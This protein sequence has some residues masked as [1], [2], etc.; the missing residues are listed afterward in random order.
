MD[1][2]PSRGGGPMQVLLIIALLGG[3]G[4]WFFDRYQVD[5]VD[6]LSVRAKSPLDSRSSSMTLTRVAAR[7]GLTDDAEPFD[8]STWFTP[9]SSQ[10]IVSARTLGTDIPSTPPRGSLASAA[11]GQRGDPIHVRHGDYPNV[12]IA[13]WAL[14]GFGP[15]RWADADAR[16]LLASIV[17]RFDVVALQQIRSGER[18]LVPRLVDE[19]NA[20]DNHYDY[21]L[22]PVLGRGDDAGEQLA[23]VFDTTTIDVDRSQTYTVDDPEDA[24]RY[25]PLVG[26]FRT[27]A[28]PDGTAWTFSLVNVR[29]DL[30]RAAAEV[31]RLP[32]IVAAVASDGRGE[33]DV[34][35]A[36]LL[37]ADDAY[38]IPTLRDRFS[39]AVRNHATDVDD[40][41]QTAN[42]LIDRRWTTEAIGR[43]GVYDFPRRHGLSRTQ[44]A[45]VS[46]HLPVW[47]EFTSH[48]GGRL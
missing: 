38:L 18:D 27:A 2:S 15:T 9:R 14:G 20:G 19:I 22:G 11:A 7:L 13:S 28:P 41:Y 29:V 1:E 40:R 46:P 24:M 39:A 34:V 43:G 25:E 3:G 12:R 42:L 47:A 21:V 16:R 8:D 48:E 33:D 45:A 17:R 23:F 32:D 36:G 6:Q 5:G 31:A 10:T 44:A 4:Y 26:W 37:Q 35:V 30:S